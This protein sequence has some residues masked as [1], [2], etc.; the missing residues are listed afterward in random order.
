[1]ICAKLNDSVHVLE[2]AIQLLED[3][4]TFR[5]QLQY[6]RV[7]TDPIRIR[8]CFDSILISSYIEQ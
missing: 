1:M 4:V 2:S 5:T 7:P 6:L 8:I 3:D